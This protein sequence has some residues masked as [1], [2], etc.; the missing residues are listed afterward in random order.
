MEVERKK[1][2][3]KEMGKKI[4]NFLLYCL[5]TFDIKKENIAPKTVF[6]PKA[7]SQSYECY[8]CC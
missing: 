8:G 6:H 5:R 4:W 2:R 3:S 7:E 1:K